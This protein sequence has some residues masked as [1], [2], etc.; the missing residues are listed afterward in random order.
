MRGDEGVDDQRELLNGF[1]YSE[2]AARNAATSSAG[3]FLV[4]LCSKSD[5][6]CRIRD[7]TEGMKAIFL[8]WGQDILELVKRGLQRS[9]NPMTQL[10]LLLQTRHDMSWF[11]TQ[12]KPC[13]RS[14]SSCDAF[15]SKLKAVEG[16]RET[17]EVV[18]R[19][20]PQPRQPSMLPQ[21]AARISTN[22]PSASHLRQ[23]LYIANLD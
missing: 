9:V 7:L 23:N 2:K 14:W 10:A 4:D 20:P 13:R 11:L 17:G 22:G 8:H 6:R 15:L 21:S 1:K 16:Q 3:V 12:L 5:D 19:T 18:H